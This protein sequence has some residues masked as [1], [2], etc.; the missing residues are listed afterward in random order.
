MKTGN[1]AND[2]YIEEEMKNQKAHE[3]VKAAK[4][5]KIAARQAQIDATTDLLADTEEVTN[6]T[7]GPESCRPIVPSART[8]SRR[9]RQTTGPPGGG[10]ALPI[11]PA[12]RSTT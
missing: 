1:V 10:G 3:E 11:F 5:E 7:Q 9:R 4:E 12:W 8:S 2:I 6:T